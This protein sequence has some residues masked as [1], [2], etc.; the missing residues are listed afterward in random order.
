MPNEIGPNEIDPNE[1]GP[2][3]I[4][5]N[6][7]DTNIDLY[8]IDDILAIFNLDIPTEFNVKDV[9]NALIAKYKNQE[10]EVFF[11]K[12]RDKVLNYLKSKAL[13][14]AE[15]ENATTESLNKIWT[16]K[17]I[18]QGSVRYFSDGSHIVPENREEA[19]RE[20][21]E[22]IIASHIINI[23]SQYRDNIL[24]YADNNPLKS[25]YNTRFTF[26]LTNPI[27]RVTSLKLYSYQIPTSWNAFNIQSGNTFF[28]YNGILITIPDGN[29]TP[30]TLALAI[31]TIAALNIASSGL[32]VTYNNTTNR[33]IFTNNDILSQTITIIFY[34]QANVI[35]YNNC[36]N[37]TLSSFQTFGINTTLGWLLGF[38]TSPDA[39]TGDVVVTIEPGES[40]PAQ[41]PPDTNGPKYFVLSLEDYSNHRLSSGLY[42]IT[43]IKSYASLSVPDYYK[44][45]NVA[46]KL[47][48]GSLTQAQQFSINAITAANSSTNNVA[49]GFNNKLSGP[50]SGTA[51]AVIPLSNIKAIRPEPYIKFGADL[52]LFKRNYLS[53]TILQRF[54]IS[55]TDDKGILV[56]LYD[57]DWSVSFIVEERLN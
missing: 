12:A 22:P 1:I 35:N 36:G 48:E 42:N 24:P 54:T 52:A 25:S 10:L 21:T 28:M 26:N 53:P 9:G 43:N 34:I 5:P 4:D 30:Q 46:C 33:I 29:Y 51:I 55:L 7:I 31:T 27:A 17:G 50:N 45:I 38:R 37:F 39:T 6:E 20:S 13:E 18:N 47:N 49:I 23:D 11:T 16:E 41:V 40:I 19:K 14:D 8:S 2:N 44:T 56:N 32:V 15:I 3:E 57:N